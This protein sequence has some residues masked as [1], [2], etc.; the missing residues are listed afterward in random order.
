MGFRSLLPRCGSWGQC[1]SS[2]L[3]ATTFVSAG[4]GCLSVCFEREGLRQ[5]RMASNSLWGQ[6]WPWTPDI[7]VVT[8]KILGCRCVHYRRPVLPGFRKARQAFYKLQA[9]LVFL[10]LK[11]GVAT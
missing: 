10:F 2:G 4:P 6:G 1:S 3:R 7:P 9:Q 5:P 8:S 11:Q